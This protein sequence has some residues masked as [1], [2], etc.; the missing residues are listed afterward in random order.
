MRTF[1]LSSALLLSILSASPVFA[2]DPV[3]VSIE[4]TPVN[5]S[6]PA[7]FARP[8]T[9][10]GIYSDGSARDLT[11]SAAWS[12]TDEAV[13][14]VSHGL[15]TGVSAGTT[16]ISAQIDSVLGSTNLTVTDVVLVGIDLTPTNPSLPVGGTQQFTATGTFSDSSTLDLTN[17]VNW[18]SDNAA[19]AISNNGFATALSVGSATITAHSDSIVGTTTLTVDATPLVSFEITSA[20][21]IVLHHRK[22]QFHAIGHFGDG[23]TYDLTQF[24]RWKSSKRKVAAISNADGSRGVA[25]TLVDGR[26][27]VSARYAGFAAATRMHVVSWRGRSITHRS[28]LVSIAVLPANSRLAR[29]TNEQFTAIGTF[30]DSTTA[31]ITEEVTWST[32]NRT[33]AQSSNAADSRGLTTGLA[34]GAT[35]VVA[36]SGSVVGTTTLTVTNAT[37]VSIQIAPTNPAVARG[38]VL[39]LTAIGTFSDGSTQDLTGQATWS[40][41]NHSVATIS[42][43]ADSKGLATGVAGGSTSAHAQ[44][45][46]V[47]GSTTMFVG[48]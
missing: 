8:F 48:N 23:S 30:A 24:V 4:V 42:N 31:D 2:A 21:P 3:L 13:A 9:A 32:S 36:Q 45:N 35:Q 7:G 20:N 17:E 39:Q 22:V 34:A 33:V 11:N 19:A 26:T 18:S 12:S 37:L 41:S 6:V 43:A 28:P 40:T 1:L 25:R 27:T 14:T 46:A 29:N 47:S 44:L 15:V 10:T 16:Q 38:A 5:A